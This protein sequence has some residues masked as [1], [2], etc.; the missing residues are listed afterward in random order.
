MK[1]VGQRLSRLWLIVREL[2]RIP[3]YQ[4]EAERLYRHLRA[5]DARPATTVQRKQ[6]PRLR[7]ERLHRNRAALAGL[8][9][10]VAAWY[11]MAVAAAG[12]AAIR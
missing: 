3:E 11:V 4:E 5:S 1:T 12:G 9:A 7:L 10:L 6:E 2:G 8:A